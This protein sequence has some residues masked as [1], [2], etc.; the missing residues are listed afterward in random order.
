MRFIS[1]IAARFGIP[2]TEKVM[3]QSVPLIGAAGGAMI[4]V[5]FINHFQEMARGHFIVLRLESKYG[6]DLVRLAY[7]EI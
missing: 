6:A 7:S 2:V 1:Q 5:L 3:A 4:N